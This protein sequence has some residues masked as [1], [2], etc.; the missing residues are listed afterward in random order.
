MFQGNRLLA[1]FALTALGFA[2][3]A[4]PYGQNPLPPYVRLPAGWEAKYGGSIVSGGLIKGPKG[5]EIF[6]P[7]YT[8]TGVV[9][10]SQMTLD[11]QSQ[12]FRA[13]IGGQRIDVALT[14]KN[15]LA[16][17]YPSAD[18][19]TEV[20]DARQTV[21]A[22]MILLTHVDES[23][24]K[25]DA[26]AVPALRIRQDREDFPFLNLAVSFAYDKAGDA[27]RRQGQPEGSNSWIRGSSNPLPTVHIW[28]NS[29]TVAG[30]QLEVVEDSNRNFHV[31]FTDRN[32]KVARYIAS[33][34][35]PAAALLA[36]LASICRV[37]A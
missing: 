24:T 18:Y 14:S 32:H 17:S 21:T 8:R 13:T 29:V 30:G 27:F 11:M 15:L 33:P 28:K 20:T 7:A 2:G 5:E 35:D 1:T 34:G 10:Y 9:A 25:S 26:P 16:V 19:W 4:N 3:S 22:F 6:F 23:P 36:I 31:Q 37:K 12:F